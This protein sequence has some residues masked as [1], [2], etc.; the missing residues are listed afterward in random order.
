[1]KKFLY[2]C[3]TVAGLLA[4][5]TVA[6]AAPFKAAEYNPSVVA[7]YPDG[8]HG[9]VSEPEGNHLGEDL[10]LK[11]G[12]SGIFQQWSYGTQPATGTGL[13]GDHDVWMPLANGTCP[14]GTTTVPNA[15]PG[16]GDYLKPNT[17]YCVRNNEFQPA[18]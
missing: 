9:V 1:M 2:M 15:Y 3:C 18:Q 6:F 7:Y 14:V 16:W 12:T 10:V 13:H 4:T 11:N 8:W 17:T 5:P